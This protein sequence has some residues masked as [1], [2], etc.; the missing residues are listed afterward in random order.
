MQA[1]SQVQL[2][3]PHCAS[4]VADSR[5]SHC[6]TITLHKQPTTAKRPLHRTQLFLVLCI[7]SSGSIWRGESY[8][9]AEAEEMRVRAAG[10]PA[11]ARSGEQNKQG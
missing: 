4:I 2:P 10:R 1:V 9:G 3:P 6:S 11:V 8:T 5:P 7:A